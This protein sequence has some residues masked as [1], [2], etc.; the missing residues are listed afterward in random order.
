MAGIW[1]QQPPRATT[2]LVS[3]IIKQLRMN[4]TNTIE[5]ANGRLEWRQLIRIG[6]LIS[7]V[8]F[9]G[10][11]KPFLVEYEAFVTVTCACETKTCMNAQ[12]EQA[13]RN[14]RFLEESAEDPAHLSAKFG[15]PYRDLDQKLRSCQARFNRLEPQ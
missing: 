7:L 12:L 14:V 13:S 1:Y 15:Q 8:A 11:Q 6:A 4:H 9:I 5:N 10:C 2:D 3:D